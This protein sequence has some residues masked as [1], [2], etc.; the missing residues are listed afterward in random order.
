MARKSQAEITVRQPEPERMSG[1]RTRFS[2]T[3][4]RKIVWD[5]LVKAKGDR[6][7]AAE[8]LGKSVRT[9]N[10]YVRDL[11]LYADMDKAGMIKN[12]GPPRNGEPPLREGAIVRHITK[13]HGEID[14]DE[15]C[16]EMYGQV[17]EKFMARV[18]VAVSELRGKGVIALDGKRWFVV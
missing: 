18:Y 3:E 17:T 15:L 14:Y 4:M 10:R 13:N 8:I 5:A 12:A 16:V 11:N 1:M 6:D 7:I 9:L 2:T